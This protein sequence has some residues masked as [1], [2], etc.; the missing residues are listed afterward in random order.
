MG[1]DPKF[2]QIKPNLSGYIV[3]LMA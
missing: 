2:F 3:T 1:L